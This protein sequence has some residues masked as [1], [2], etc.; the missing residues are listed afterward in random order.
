[1]AVTIDPQ[2]AA[3]LFADRLATQTDAADVHAALAGG[4]PGFVLIDARNSAAWAQG[5]IPG[6]LHLPHAEIPARAADLLDLA[7]PVVTY[8]WGPG[9]NGATRA[10][11]ALSLLGYAA[12]E[13]IGGIEYWAREGFA[14]RRADGD[15][16]V[17]A[18]PLVTLA[19]QSPG[20]AAPLAPS[21][22]TRPAVPAGPACGC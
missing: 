21:A 2:R 19:P 12:R 18:D 10:A 13:M 6:A 15:V 16:A 20:S 17:P 7:V 14:L 8:C 11:L 1:M 9:C 5:H 4:K 22:D 3:V